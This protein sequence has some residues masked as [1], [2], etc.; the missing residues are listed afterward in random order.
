M[1]EICLSRVLLADADRA[2]PLAKAGGLDIG[3]AV[4]DAGRAVAVGDVDGVPCCAEDVD[5][6]VE[7]ACTVP[8]LRAF[9]STASAVGNVVL[10]A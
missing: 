9:S 4:A 8:T 2:L 1:C 7:K 10:D 3:R 6:L 5:C